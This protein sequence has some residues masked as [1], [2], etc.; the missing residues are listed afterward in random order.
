MTNPRPENKGGDSLPRHLLDEILRLTTQGVEAAQEEEASSSEVQ[1][2]KQVVRRFS[3]QALALDPMIVALVE[4]MLSE[5]FGS[6]LE[7]A[8]L[9]SMSKWVAD[10]LW[11]DPVARRRI[12]QLWVQLDRAA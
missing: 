1:L 2:L 5:E 10:S 9:A 4:A 12:E 8:E 3:G 11:D 6:A 7:P